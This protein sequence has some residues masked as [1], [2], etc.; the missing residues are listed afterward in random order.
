MALEDN[1]DQVI[2]Q[3]AD[4]WTAAMQ[5]GADELLDKSNQLVPVD[6]GDLRNSGVASA[7]GKE[8]AVAYTAP[9]AMKQHERL[10]FD[11]PSGGQAKFLETAALANAS[12]I[13]QAIAE[14][15]RE[16]L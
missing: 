15:M 1:T 9:H 4:A 8:A 11:H 2:D 16:Q 12:A 6:D 10:D 14:A 3:I 7:S 13:E 5:A